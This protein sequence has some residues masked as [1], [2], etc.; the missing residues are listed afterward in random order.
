MVEGG[1]GFKLVKENLRLK[2]N[3][4]RTPPD[5]TGRRNPERGR[6]SRSV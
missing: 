4:P 2:V 3:E 6:F 1:E 5:I